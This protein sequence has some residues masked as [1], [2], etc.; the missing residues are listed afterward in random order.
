M[1]LKF[2]DDVTVLTQVLYKSL[3][4]CKYSNHICRVYILI[5]LDFLVSNIQ[6]Q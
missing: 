2:A 4:C 6:Y 5:T 1:L 3:H